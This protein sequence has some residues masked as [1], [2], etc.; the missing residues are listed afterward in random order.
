MRGLESEGG[1]AL[2]RRA[3]V[4][5]DRRGLWKFCVGVPDL[6]LLT[7]H[8]KVGHAGGTQSPRALRFRYAS[9]AAGGALPLQHT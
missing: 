3:D 2:M 7:A 6:T 4:L 1:V 5:A 9:G 8:S